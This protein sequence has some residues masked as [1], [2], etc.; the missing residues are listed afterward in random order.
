MQQYSNQHYILKHSD[1]IIKDTQQ[2]LSEKTHKEELDLR[3]S[4]EIIMNVS[5]VSIWK[6]Y[7]DEHKFYPLLGKILMLD[8]TTYEE[9]ANS[10]A[11][12][13]R[14]EY[15]TIFSDLISG[16]CDKVRTTFHFIHPETRE[17]IYYQ[18]ELAILL[19]DSGVRTTIIGTQKD[20]TDDIL[21]KQRLE[22]F[23]IKTKLTNEKNHIIQWDYNITQQHII[24]HGNGAIQEGVALDRE[25]YLSY[26]H[27]EDRKLMGNF[28]DK[29]SRGELNIF[30]TQI[31]TYLPGHKE[32][33]HVVL[34]ALEQRDK[35]GRIIGYTG[36]RR[37]ATDTVL[38]DAH[39]KESKFKTDMAMKN[40]NMVM[41]EYNVDER[42]FTAFNDP[43]TNYDTTAKYTPEQY[44]AVLDPAS[45]KDA[46]R[47]IAFMD[48]RELGEFSFKSKIMLPNSTQWQYITIH[49][50]HSEVCGDDPTKGQKYVGFRLDNT[51]LVKLSQGLEESNALTM[52]ILTQSPSAIFIKDVTN[53]FRYVIGNDLFCQLFNY[54]EEQIIGYTDHE[55]FSQEMADKFHEDD[56]KAIG[57]DGIYSFIEEVV[58]DNKVQALH[59]TKRIITTSNGRKL[60]IGISSDISET[61]TQHKQLKNTQKYLDLAIDAGKVAVWGYNPKKD[62]V[63][64]ISGQVFD[65][66][67][68]PFSEAAD[69]IYP[70]DLPHFQEVWM[71]IIN[72][73]SDEESACMRFR[74]PF[75]NQFE[76]I[77]KTIIALHT[78]SGE[79]DMIIGTHHD[80]TKDKLQ[81]MAL[82]NSNEKLNMA[83]DVI[84]AFSWHCDQRDEILCF[85]SN[86]ASLGVNAEEMNS[87]IKFSK[88]IHPDDRQGFLDIIEAFAQK[89]E[90]EFISTYRIDLRNNGNYEWWECRGK[91]K[92][93]SENGQTY[94][95]IY[96]MNCNVT[97]HKQITDELQIAKERAEQSDKLKSAFLA[98]MSHEIRTPLNAIVGF[99]E[100]LAN[101]ETTEERE[102][103]TNIISVNNELLLRLID[104]ILDLSKIESGMVELKPE[105]FDLSEICDE[106][107]LM[108]KQKVTNPK[109]NFLV[110]NPYGSCLVYLDRNRLKQVGINFITNAIKYT[111]KGTIKM[112]YE[113]IDQ[114]VKIYVQDTGIGISKE[115]YGKIFKRFEKFDTFAQGT[116]LGLSICK[117]IMDVQGGKIGFE[118]EAG[119]G[120]CFWAWFPGEANIRERKEN[121]KRPLCK[122][123]IAPFASGFSTKKN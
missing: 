70:D 23:Q 40:A 22:E 12:D 88:H 63:F 32:Y 18:S 4:L 56:L 109:I 95:Y 76:Y 20:I 115:N 21:Q 59:T 65:R 72:G 118:S 33:R 34:N 64:N 75:T 96:G 43:L 94:K 9:C 46:E 105:T 66:D 55:I 10:I 77:D 78:E 54:T 26:I 14:E 44:I 81:K 89:D 3:T 11:E 73:E 87:M 27:P 17:D 67:E 60:L 45:I 38:M 16:K 119:E 19:D 52:S 117:A 92:I 51:E 97:R 101:A 91:M 53:D 15:H 48:R 82:E 85:D 74:N 99:S 71:K 6:Y 79:L 41:W 5:E 120:S 112:G 69:Y 1:M 93:L 31:R 100:L 106:V 110:E 50:S 121:D 24:T 107:Y 61:I 49:G 68:L 84:G 7:I 57:Y 58:T 35:R 29:M 108:L 8:G 36:I 28:L 39:I 2:L 114:G 47:A 86:F 103:Y 123:P 116:G 83:L 25:T 90:D 13:S 98:N 42:T 62:V 111:A 37:D 102:E 80:V 122:Y 30:D 104:D 113:Y